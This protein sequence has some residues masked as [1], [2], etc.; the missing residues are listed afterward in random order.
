M[1]AKSLLEV[2]RQE[3]VADHRLPSSV[4]CKWVRGKFLPPVCAC[5]SMSRGDLYLHSE[6]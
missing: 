3:C 1:A 4:R 6:G 5:L 2:R